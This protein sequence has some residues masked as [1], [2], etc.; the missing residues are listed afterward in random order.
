MTDLDAGDLRA[1]I[2]CRVSTAKQA[3]SGLSLE[4]Q[5][6]RC[7][8]YCAA[9]GYDVRQTVTET[10]SAK[11]GPYGRPVLADV[12]DRLD[13]GVFDVLVVAGLDRLARST[14]DMLTV[15][16]RADRHR[17]SFAL[18]DLNLDTSSPVGRLSLTVV[19]AV[20]EF[21]RRLI[22]ERTRNALAAARARGTK[23]GRPTSPAIL[24][25]IPTIVE[26]RTRGRSLNSIARQLN[27]QQI[28]TATGAGPWGPTQVRRALDAAEPET[29]VKCELQQAPDF[30]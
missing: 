10:I 15:A 28:T 9:K 14:R 16:V 4:S 30:E 29:V 12:L 23:I 26:M 24:E 21:E 6:N 25:A 20:A 13:S 11:I 7:E 2:Y 19:A 8:S 3:E 27:K 5:Q 22:S 17:W 1:V 18:L